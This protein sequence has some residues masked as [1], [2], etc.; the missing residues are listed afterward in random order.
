MSPLGFALTRSILPSAVTKTPS[1]LLLADR[2]LVSEIGLRDEVSPGIIL[3]SINRC[4]SLLD[5]VESLKSIIDQVN[6]IVFVS[7]CSKGA[8]Q[9]GANPVT[10]SMV[11]E[12][13][14]DWARVFPCHM[15]TLD[16]FLVQGVVPESLMIELALA[17]GAIVRVADM[18]TFGSLRTVAR[19]DLGSVVASS[20]RKSFS[21]AN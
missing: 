11:R 4:E 13:P 14:E 1:I 5:Q 19:G 16:L 3:V 8:M 15:K 21:R 20:T 12:T 7:R 6:S 9:I 18:C 2:E 10:T 17:T